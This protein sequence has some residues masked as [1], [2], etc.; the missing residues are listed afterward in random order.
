MMGNATATIPPHSKKLPDEVR[1]LEKVLRGYLEPDQVEAVHRAYLASEKAHRGQTRKSGEAYIFHP[2]ATA[3]ILAEMAMDQQTIAAALL[4]DTIEDTP[5]TKEQVLEQFGAPVAALVDGVTKLEKVRFSSAKEAAAESFR[6]MLLAM[7]QDIRVILIKLADRLH[8]MRTLDAMRPDKRR[9]IARETL[10]V[11][12]PIAQRLGMDQVKRELQDLGFRALHPLRYRVIR[13]QVR[14]A[15]GRNEEK[16]KTIETALKT[17]LKAAGIACTIEFRAKS[18]FSIYRKMKN[19]TIAFEDI[20]DLLGFR[21]VVN[22]VSRCYQTLGVVHNLYKPRSGKF[23]DYIAIPK[24]NGYQSLHT[25][26]FGPFGDPIEI[27]IRTPEMDTVSERGIAA[28]WTYKLDGES[29]GQTAT[30]AREWLL[31]VLDMQK[32]AGDSIEFLEHVKLDL[33]PDEIYVFTPTGDIRELPRNSTVLDFAYS[34]HTDVGNHAV[35]A[36]V[37]KK[38]VPLRYRISSGETVQIIT[39]PS[40]EP[41][42]SWLEFVATSRARTAIRHYLKN[43]TH[44][45]AVQMGHLMLDRALASRGFSLDNLGEDRLQEFLA[46]VKL[47]RLE[48][49]LRD[50]ALGNRMPNLVARQLCDQ[51]QDQPEE[52]QIAEEAL[53]LTGAEGRLVSYGNCCHPIPGDPVMGFLSAGKGLVIH[54]TSC[55]NLKELRKSRDRWIDVDWNPTDPSLFSVALKVDVL[56]RPGVLATAASAISETDTNIEHVVHQERDGETSVLMFT[57]S[58]Q[59][60]KHLARV[61]RRL[62]RTGLVIG[63]HRTIS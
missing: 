45:D 25:I 61:M 24:A 48:D 60:R 52:T 44:E 28:H 13:D 12:A 11:Y 1:K 39:T 20:L 29:G 51:H 18:P 30:R 3:Q 58:V 23:K 49:L 9:R 27:Q 6:K 5:L 41:R 37:D 17:H 32:Q 2:V 43:L 50:V 53:Q 63:V 31:G 35:H 34:V 36:W 15:K 14:K 59:G 16:L 33:F 55:R 8:N 22:S 40:A 54:R 42:P 57:L 7:A 26:L 47:K 56:N 4:H 21:I 46:S 38:L 19:K 62:R 10:E